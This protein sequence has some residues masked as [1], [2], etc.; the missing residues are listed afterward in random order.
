MT[1]SDKAD[2]GLLLKKAVS[3]ACGDG[4]S[5]LVNLVVF[6]VLLRFLS[7]SEF[8][9]LSVGQALSVWVQPVLYMGANLVAVRAIAATPQ[10]VAVIARRMVAVRFAAAAA[11]SACTVVIALHT[12][13]RSL[14]AVL[15]AYA[16]LF[17]FY[18]LQPDFIA[19]GLHRA[20]VY[21]VSRFVGSTCF[22]VL[23]LMLTRHS[24]RA[25]MVPLAY[26]V[27]L[28]LSAVYGVTKLW[29]FLHDS[30]DGY[31][32]SSWAICR[33]ALIVVAAQFLQMGQ[34]SLD[35][36]LLKIW[37]LPLALIGDYSAIARLTST[38]CLPFVALIYALAPLYVNELNGG[39][40]AKIRRLE[41]RFRICL[42]AAG[43]VGATAI[44]TIGPASLQLISG[45]AMPTAQHLA[46][47][48][49]LTCLVIALHNSYTAILVYGGATH[50]Y[51][52]TYAAGFIAT[53]L[54]AL[55]LIPRYGT[56]GAGVSE[57]AG[58]TVILVVSC[59]LHSQVIQRQ[60]CATEARQKATVLVA[61]SN[62][63]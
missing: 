49:A 58:F 13:D 10:H 50:L 24:L 62:D 27:A 7:P 9:Y 57:L 39:D 18:P 21:T 41:C 52:A 40:M 34:V 60:H 46:P 31:N 33:S 20:R 47:V 56:L 23:V 22:L 14:M 26:A 6:T 19:I 43:I 45:R 59:Y 16:F 28:L 54:A 32:I 44:V 1:S 63:G 48:F 51:F 15:V 25:W 55:M 4:S 2:A 29:P 3:Y 61:G 30:G 42:L 12:S 36:I 8:G 35:V 38:A 53:L 37:K 11:V 5:T 17:L